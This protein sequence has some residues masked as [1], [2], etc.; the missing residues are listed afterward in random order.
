MIKR[1]RVIAGL[2]DQLKALRKEY[3]V[4]GA[5]LTCLRGTKTNPH[6]IFLQTL[7]EMDENKKKEIQSERVK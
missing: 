5:E 7:N 6:R 1:K 4:D 3:K 2:K